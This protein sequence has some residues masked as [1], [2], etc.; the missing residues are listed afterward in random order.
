MRERGA[1]RYHGRDRVRPDLTSPG[2]KVKAATPVPRM[3]FASSKLNSAFAKAA[4]SVAPCVSP[5][6]LPLSGRR[7]SSAPSIA[8]ASAP[9]F[10]P[11]SPALAAASF[12]AESDMV[13]DAVA[14]GA[15]ALAIAAGLWALSEQKVSLRL[16]RVLKT[17]AA[18]T[19]AAVGE[20]DAL[21]G[22][23]REGLI[24]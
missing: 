5:G 10:A 13:P 15:V 3:R 19:R 17:A 23:A 7:L 2:W 8:R 1:L 14:A 20:R 18:R 22:A 12:V 11:A 24:V 4:C 16:R 9:A 6:M 21:L